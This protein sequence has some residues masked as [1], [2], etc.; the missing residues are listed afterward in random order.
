[1][2]YWAISYQSKVTKWLKSIFVCKFTK[3]WATGFITGSGARSFVVSAL[4]PHV[5]Y[6]KAAR[7]SPR[8]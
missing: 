8:S 3:A 5:P 4:A 7:Q 6:W 2:Q 1:M